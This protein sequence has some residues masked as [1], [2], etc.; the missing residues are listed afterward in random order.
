MS[1]AQAG[2]LG[3]SAG[4]ALGA[5]LAIAITDV[6]R[7]NKTVDAYGLNEIASN[8][9]VQGELYPGIAEAEARIVQVEEERL[10]Y[11][12]T[13]SSV[14]RWGDISTDGPYRLDTGSAFT[15]VLTARPEP[16][17]MNDLLNLAP[18]TLV[19]QTPANTYLL[20]ESIVVL[21]GATLNLT[22]EDDLTI[23]LESN[24]DRF[25]SIVALGGS[26]TVAGSDAATVSLTSWDSESA[27]V[28]TRTADGRSYVRVIGGHAA[29]SHAGFASLGF[30]SGNTGGVALT[31]AD[32]VGQFD[33][34]TESPAADESVPEVAGALLLPPGELS[35]LT[36]EAGA[37]NPFVSADIKEVS[38]TGN[39]FGLF[40]TSAVDVLVRDTKITGSLVDGLVFHRY[41]TD[42]TVTRT[43]S[44][45]NAVDGFTVSRSS[46]GIVFS[47][48]T[49]SGNGR[50]GISIDGQALADGPS[51]MGTA[52]E[53]YGDNRVTD[54]RVMDNGRYGIEISGSR[55]VVLTANAIEANMVG[56]VLNH[57]ADGTL[58]QDNTFGD[59]V[60]QSIALR[61]GVVGAEIR[62]NTISGS[63]TGV[64]VRDSAVA[65]TG[66]DMTEVSNHGITLIG[67]ASNVA[68]THNSI[69]GFGSTPI[70]QGDSVGA[71]LRDNKILDW[72]P[73]I[74]PTSVVKSVFQPLTVVWLSLGLLLVATAL[75][76]RSL[77]FGSIRHP[78]A[79]QIPLQSLTKGVVSRQ[80]LEEN[81][82]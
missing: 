4:L 68:V 50:N 2:L 20:S 56:V 59:Q 48:V 72:H 18:D 41:V 49:S 21:E 30:W 45:D 33:A 61:D 26:L 47:E 60:E 19:R 40:V 39:A 74:T 57:G 55:D 15:L 14:A 82:S 37:R 42:S 31:G 81:R 36:A 34:S 38:F 6:I 43:S 73:A 22:S 3:A 28:D 78:Y 58:V 75:S 17:T 76:P 65:I 25:V 7:S 44:S 8:G 23:R 10:V 16:Y 35:E 69:A 62:D 77:R 11:V 63:N 12:R 5:I 64:Y 80:A 9:T 29:M 70:H 53:S 51:A 1:R 32:A 66:N 24:P 71:H 52:V 46:T 13:V 27:A 54:S 67:D 79:E